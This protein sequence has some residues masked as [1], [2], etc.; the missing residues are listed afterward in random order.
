MAFREGFE[1]PT[2][3]LEDPSDRKKEVKIIIKEKPETHKQRAKIFLEKLP[4]EYKELPPAQLKKLL[5]H[6]EVYL[7]K[8]IMNNQPG[9]QID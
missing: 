2:D 6:T 1:P 7:H 5:M 8:S 4:K 3:G 9:T